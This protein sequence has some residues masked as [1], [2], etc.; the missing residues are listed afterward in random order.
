MPG[1]PRG[2]TD[3]DQRGGK[4]GRMVGEKGIKRC[5]GGVRGSEGWKETEETN[6]ESLYRR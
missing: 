1:E 5:V 4:R 2:S 6:G 3:M